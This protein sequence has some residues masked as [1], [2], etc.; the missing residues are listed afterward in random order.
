MRNAAGFRLPLGK[1]N[2]AVV[3]LRAVVEA[4]R[5]DD[6]VLPPGVVERDDGIHPA[7]EKNDGFHGW[8][9]RVRFA[10]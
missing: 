9:R 8:I 10:K 4:K 1:R 5:R 2:L 7:A 3:V 6:L